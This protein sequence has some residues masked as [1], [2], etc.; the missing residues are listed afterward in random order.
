MNIILKK[1]VDNLG[2]KDDLLTV[3]S[4]YARNFLI[5]QGL[6]VLATPSAQKVRTEDL[7]QRAHREAKIR[8]EATAL[9][10]KLARCNPESGCQSGRRW[11]QDLR[12]GK[13]HPSGRSHQG[14][15]WNRG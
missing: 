1:D 11:K 6:A 12:F 4:G 15:S 13:Q 8:E 9:G 5:P 3:K 14:S 10:A 2:Y 7:K